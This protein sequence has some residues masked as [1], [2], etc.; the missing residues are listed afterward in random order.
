LLLKVCVEFIGGDS[1]AVSLQ[2]VFVD[3]DEDRRDIFE[4]LVNP[5]EV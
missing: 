5:S 4:E 2:L 1:G 3:I